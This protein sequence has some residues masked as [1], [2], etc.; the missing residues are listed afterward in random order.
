MIIDFHTHN[1]PDALA[2]KAMAALKQNCADNPDIVAH[3]DGTA[4]DAQ[5]KL[6][7]AGVDHA[8]VCNIATNARQEEKVNSYA[9]SLVNS[10]FFIPLGSLHPDSE[11]KRAELKRLSDAGI[12]GIKLHPDYVGIE[13]SDTR[14]D[15]IFSLLCEYDMFCV[16]HAGYDPISPE[17]V[18]ATP[19]MFRAVIDKYPDLK[20]VAAH[21]GGFA[22]AEGVLEHLVG[23]N[24]YI[25]TSL[26]SLRGYEKELLYK[27]LSE[28]REDRLLFGTDT[29]WTEAAEEIE[30]IKNAPISEERKEKIFYKNAL[31]LLKLETEQ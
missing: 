31:K 28:H 11:N 23:T 8:V 2:P 1:F 26:S 21:M 6:S 15:E 10:D 30:F 3:T 12:K 22:K 13:L 19:E 7:A 18:H 20:L 16:V 14:Y 9:I 5:K 29:P 17:K 27:I 4:A 24:V 25:D